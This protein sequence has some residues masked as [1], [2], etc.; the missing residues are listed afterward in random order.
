LCGTPQK[1]W[2]RA[3]LSTFFAWQKRAAPCP[4]SQNAVFCKHQARDFMRVTE[5]QGTQMKDRRPSIYA[6]RKNAALL[7][8]AMLV[9]VIGFLPACS[10]RAALDD[11]SAAVREDSLPAGQP[12]LAETAHAEPPE[13][14]AE[15]AEPAAPA[16]EP[17][18]PANAGKPLPGEA[19]AIA[20]AP[21]ELLFSTEYGTESASQILISFVLSADKSV[22]RDL[23]FR[24]SGIT[25]AGAL[26]E[27]ITSN[28]PGLEFPVLGGHL[29]I[30]TDDIDLVLDIDGESAIGASAIHYHFAGVK[31]D[32][33]MKIVGVEYPDDVPPYDLDLGT[34]EVAF[35]A[36]AR[37]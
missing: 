19:G 30:A 10:G 23:V 35:A 11:A 34:S 2:D 5:R 31:I 18:P 29:E 20:L 7:A 27:T 6:G 22:V 28:N 4:A 26:A 21:G 9:I 32:D 14:A 25:A 8:A 33:S 16:A 15:P 13:S 3:S 17:A 37:G 12:D 36:A 1:F 24:V